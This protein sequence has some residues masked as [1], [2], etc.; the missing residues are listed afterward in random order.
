MKYSQPPLLHLG[1]QFDCPPGDQTSSLVMNR[2]RA[3]PIGVD[4]GFD[5]SKNRKVVSGNHP[6]IN[7]SAFEVGIALVNERGL[8]LRGRDSREMKHF[9][10]VVV[11]IWVF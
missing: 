10:S 7:D 3:L 4:P 5:H 6:G 11:R 9:E 8:N 2:S 1:P